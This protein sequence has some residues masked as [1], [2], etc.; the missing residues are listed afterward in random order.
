MIDISLPLKNRMIT[1]PGDAPYEEYVHSDHETD[2]VHIMRVIMETHSGTHFDAPFHMIPNG[3]KANQVELEK[4]IGPAT[5]LEVD[6][7]T[8]GEK[9]IPNTH[10]ER[11]LFKTKNSGLYEDFKENFTYLTLEGAKKLAR[12]G[13]KLVGI[14]YL[15]IEE[16]GSEEMLVHKELMKNDIAILEGLNLLNVTPGDYELICLPLNMSQDGAPC[17]AILR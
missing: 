17:R 7:E 16:F 2:R 13:V 10:Q 14:D 15:S 12:N 9:D 8:I 3:K 1:Y 5:V 6:G 4:F 11:V